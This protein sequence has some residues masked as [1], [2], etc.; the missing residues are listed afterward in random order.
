MKN[1]VVVLHDDKVVE[2]TGRKVVGESPAAGGD[3]DGRFAREPI[4]DWIGWDEGGK[5]GPLFV[6]EVGGEGGVIGWER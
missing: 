6:G 4:H 1:L 2:L 5:D 3:D